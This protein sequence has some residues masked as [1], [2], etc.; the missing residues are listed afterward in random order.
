MSAV[1]VVSARTALR[2]DAIAAPYTSRLAVE[3]FPSWIKHLV[4]IKRFL[5]TTENAIGTD[6]LV[7]AHHLCPVAIVKKELQLYA[8]SIFV[9]RFS[10]YPSLEKTIDFMRPGSKR[11]QTPLCAG[12]ANHLILFDI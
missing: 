1:R 12:N 5:A 11:S 4:R 9:Y 2:A 6:T 10:R 3:L 7:H 8:N